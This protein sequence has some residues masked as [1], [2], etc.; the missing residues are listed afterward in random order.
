MSYNSVNF[1][2]AGLYNVKSSNTPFAQAQSSKPAIV[3][4]APNGAVKRFVF[5][6][7]RQRA[8]I[9]ALLGMLK[10]EPNLI[11]N[12]SARH[13]AKEIKEWLKVN[14]GIGASVSN[15]LLGK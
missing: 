3:W 13:S 11:N 8:E 4:T 9:N 10:R 1:E 7:N 2:N 12:L 15:Q 5:T 6:T 14:Y